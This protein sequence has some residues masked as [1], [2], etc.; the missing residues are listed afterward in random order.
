MNN[1]I[2]RGSSIKFVSYASVATKNFKDASVFEF[3][4]RL[5]GRISNGIYIKK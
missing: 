2:N 3:N 5:G 4:N 1:N